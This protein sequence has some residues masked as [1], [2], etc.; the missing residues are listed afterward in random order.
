MT[1]DL[2]LEYIKKIINTWQNDKSLLL[3]MDSFRGHITKDVNDLLEN[4]DC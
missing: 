4:I 1:S 3:I 2:M